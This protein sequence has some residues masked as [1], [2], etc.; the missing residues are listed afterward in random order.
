MDPEAALLDVHVGPD[1]I[2]E[3]LLGDHLAR[4][5]SKI[6][7]NIERAAAKGKHDAVTSQYPL[8]TQ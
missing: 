6:D 1:V 3:F 7:Q 5:V 4:A 2:D 8:V